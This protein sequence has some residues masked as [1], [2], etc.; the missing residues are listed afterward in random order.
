MNQIF[1]HIVRPIIDLVKQQILDF[2]ALHDSRRIEV[3]VVI[4]HS[5]F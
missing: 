5:R 4:L 1:S 2:N 3:S